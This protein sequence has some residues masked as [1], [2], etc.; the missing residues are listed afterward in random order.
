MDIIDKAV[1]V[2]RHD[3]T[4]V[5]P[6]ETVYGLG[7]DAFSD[8]AILKV[9]E[10]KERPLSMP[11]SIAVS[12]FDMLATVAQVEPHMYPFI[13]TFLPGPVTIILT[14]RMSLPGAPE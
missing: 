10:A 12:D 9:Y 7:A 6:T 13:E 2:L 4:I 5:Y 1:S 14:S 11:I 3:G 8:E